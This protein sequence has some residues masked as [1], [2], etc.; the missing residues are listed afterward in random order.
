MIL[1]VGMTLTGLDKEKAM[2]TKQFFRERP[3]VIIRGNTAYDNFTCKLG[4]I[5]SISF[6]HV[7]DRD[8]L[9]GLLIGFD[10]EDSG[11]VCTDICVNM[12]SSCKYK[13]ITERLEA[14]SFILN[15]VHELLIDAKKNELYKLKNVP[16]ELY[17]DT[18]GGIGSLLIGFRILTEV[19]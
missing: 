8:F 3:E 12:S 14:H 10:I 13:D 9:L 2:R 15:T 1:G 4:K 6:G 18:G 5:G 17:F 11:A 7:A 16:V 19:L